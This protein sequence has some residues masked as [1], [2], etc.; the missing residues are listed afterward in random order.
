MSWLL[1]FDPAY[2]AFHTCGSQDRQMEQTDGRTNRQT[3]I[4]FPLVAA[5]EVKETTRVLLY[6]RRWLLS[7]RTPSDYT[8]EVDH[9][10]T[11]GRPLY[12][13]VQSSSRD[14]NVAFYSQRNVYGCDHRPKSSLLLLPCFDSCCHELAPGIGCDVLR[15]AYLSRD[16]VSS[17]HQQEVIPVYGLSN[18]SNCDDL[19]HL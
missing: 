9:V 1:E 4:R 17:V 6:L 13:Y 18:S 2:P 12:C 19:E 5:D 15:L 14:T 7:L 10:Q 3:H 11:E 16:V 8:A